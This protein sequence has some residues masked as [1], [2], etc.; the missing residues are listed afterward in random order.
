MK[1]LTTITVSA[2]AVLTLSSCGGV[3]PDDTYGSVADLQDAINSADFRCTGE[4]S[5]TFDG[6]Y[7]EEVNCD[8]GMDIAVWEEDAP[9]YVD[10]PGM[11][12]LATSLTETNYHMLSTEQW[13]IRSSNAGLIE[14]MAPVLGGTYYGSSE[15]LRCEYGI[16]ENC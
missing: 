1:N 13:L 6:G 3:T 4:D 11:V 14:E 12:R 7:A 9:Y 10:G 15:D 2:V 16:E 8:E 5:S